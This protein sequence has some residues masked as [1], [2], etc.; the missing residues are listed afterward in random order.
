MAS[1]IRFFKKQSKSEVKLAQTISELNELKE[2]TK[3]IKQKQQQAEERRERDI[4]NQEYK[5]HDLKREVTGYK[6]EFDSYRT[7]TDSRLLEQDKRLGEV[8]KQVGIH[9]EELQRLSQKDHVLKKELLECEKSENKEAAAFIKKEKQKV[10]QEFEEEL[11]ELFKDVERRRSIAFNDVSER[12][13]TF[14]MKTQENLRRCSQQIEQN[15]VQIKQLRAEA[16]EQQHS[17]SK[18]HESFTEYRGL[19]NKW[20]YDLFMEVQDMK[21]PPTNRMMH[22]QSTCSA[23]NQSSESPYQ[24]TPERYPDYH[25]E[26]PVYEN[27]NLTPS[28]CNRA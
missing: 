11:K 13:D 14:E 25:S 4:T 20:C 21:S 15:Q 3:E 28:L 24:A 22:S 18:Q 8:E 17:I 7:V 5:I 26:Q 6:H 1:L 12:Q 9:C 27:Q 19:Q 16:D 2:T 23:L 10:A